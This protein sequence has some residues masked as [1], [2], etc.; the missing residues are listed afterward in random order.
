MILTIKHTADWY[1]IRQKNVKQIIKDNIDENNKIINH[2]YK[3]GDKSM[4]KNIAFSNM[5]PHIMVYFR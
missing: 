4:I 5:K 1:L 3:A 2:N